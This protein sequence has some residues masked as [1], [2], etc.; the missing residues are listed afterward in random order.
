LGHF[1]FYAGTPGNVISRR[2]NTTATVEHWVA[3]AYRFTKV[4]ESCDIVPD[5]RLISVRIFGSGVHAPNASVFD[6]QFTSYADMQIALHD[7]LVS[8]TGLSA[9]SVRVLNL[10]QGSVIADVEFIG[11]QSTVDN[12][13]STLAAKLG[14]DS[15][16]KAMFCNAVLATHGCGVEIILSRLI[17]GASGTPEESFAEVPSDHNGMSAVLKITII[18]SAA[19]LVSSI[20]VGIIACLLSQMLRRSSRVTPCNKDLHPASEITIDVTNDDAKLADMD[21]EDKLSLAGSTATPCSS[22]STRDADMISMASD[23]ILPA[24]PAEQE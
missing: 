11:A 13:K 22:S 1:K 3:D 5:V 10:R 19:V 12:A 7:A 15:A 23:V 21:F 9:N 14:S 16:L 24:I 20:V 6:G 8:A 4:S 17:S 2:L 18:L